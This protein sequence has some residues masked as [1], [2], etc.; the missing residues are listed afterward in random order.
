MHQTREADECS[1]ALLSSQPLFRI[2]C[3][4]PGLAS[5]PSRTRAAKVTAAT[6]LR[7][8]AVALLPAGC[9]RRRPQPRRGAAWSRW[10]CS[11]WWARE[12]SRPTGGDARRG[13]TP[14]PPGHRPDARGPTG[15]RSERLHAAPGGEA[16]GVRIERGPR[17]RQ[18]Q[19]RC[20][21]VPP[22]SQAGSG[23][24]ARGRRPEVGRAALRMRS[25]CGRASGG[26]SM[27]SR[28]KR[29]IEGSSAPQTRPY[30][31]FVGVWGSLVWASW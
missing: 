2:A 13:R 20:A 28:W 17:A 30:V 9:R 1:A 18:H 19:A 15:V 27:V 11:T 7:A 25:S 31:C 24:Q 5:R 21:V 8:A 29:W 4:A 16:E 22:W 6:A 10:T 3:R 14:P 23:R 12:L 26:R